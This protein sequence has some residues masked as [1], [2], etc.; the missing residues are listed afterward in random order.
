MVCQQ[1]R[2]WD[3]ADCFEAIVNDIRAIILDGRTVQSSCESDVRTDYDSC[4]RRR[5]SKVHM[6]VDT[7]GQLI[8]MTVTSADEQKRMQVKALCEAVKLAWADQGYT[9]EQTKQDAQASEIDRKIVKLP[10][11]REGFI[12]LA[13]RWVVERSFR[14]LSRFRRLNRDF[15]RLPQVLASLHFFVMLPKAA[16]MMAA[17][18]SSQHALGI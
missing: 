12:V 18:G 3:E 2:R 9:S 8:S 16:A 13:R 6:A 4:K 7:M 5:G 14:W 10:A 17:T 11:T 15:G 1:F